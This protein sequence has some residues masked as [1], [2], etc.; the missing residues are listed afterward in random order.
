M[1]KEYK[2]D[3]NGRFASGAAAKPAKG[4]DTAKKAALLAGAALGA[5]AAGGVLKV[6]SDALARYDART[7]AAL[8][9]AADATSA[10]PR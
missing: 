9:R 10:W 2:R 8:L 6:R 1:T 5:A 3:A 4:G 7:A